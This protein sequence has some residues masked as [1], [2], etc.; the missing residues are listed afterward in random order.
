MVFDCQIEIL[1]KLQANCD[2]FSF[3]NTKGI[4]EQ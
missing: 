2:K 3:H 4:G 1:N